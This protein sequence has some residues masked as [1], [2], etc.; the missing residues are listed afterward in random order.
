MDGLCGVKM[1]KPITNAELA[2]K[3]QSALIGDLCALRGHAK[4]FT[5]VKFAMKSMKANPFVGN[6]HLGLKLVF[7]IA[8]MGALVAM[9][10][11]S[12]ISDYFGLGAHCVPIMSNAI[13]SFFFTRP[14]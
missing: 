8:C 12:F 2:I 9:A 7:N 11:N 5:F 3:G 4:C 10:G 6:A 14:A 13:N 1:N